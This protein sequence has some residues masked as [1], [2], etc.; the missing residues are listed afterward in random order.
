MTDSARIAYDSAMKPSPDF[1]LS[2]KARKF[3]ASRIASGRSDTPTDVVE[4]ALSLLERTERE[5]EVRLEE[6]RRGV[7]RGIAAADRGEVLPIKGLLERVRA[8]VKARPN[9]SF[10]A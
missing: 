9:R 3:V 1:S 7:R 6:I 8:K 10:R 5:Q 4:D 2:A